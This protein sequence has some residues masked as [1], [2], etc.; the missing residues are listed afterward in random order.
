MVAVSF[1]TG[2]GG[3]ALLTNDKFNIPGL[4]H[5][6][7]ISDKCEFIFP[8]LC[9]TPSLTNPLFD[10]YLKRVSP[11]RESNHGLLLNTER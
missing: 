5:L 3:V 10:Q 11:Q 2:G 1:S 4:G 9:C 8:Y 6:K 7:R